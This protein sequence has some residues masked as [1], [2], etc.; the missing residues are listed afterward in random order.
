MARYGYVLGIALNST[1][2]SDAAISTLEAVH[3]RHPNDRDVLFA[4]ATMERDRGN[5][6]RAIEWTNALLRLNPADPQA[7][8]LL[9]QLG[10]IP[11]P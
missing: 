9:P 5:R 6:E 10:G 11:G 8:Q 4:L 3:D 7:E 2:Q 1:G